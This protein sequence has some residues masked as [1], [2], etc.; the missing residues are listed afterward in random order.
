MIEIKRKRYGEYYAEV[1]SKN[2]FVLATT[3]THTNISQLLDKIDSIKRIFRTEF[4][5]KHNYEKKIAKNF[6]K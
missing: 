6:T 5:I 4:V 3:G 2:G 1:V